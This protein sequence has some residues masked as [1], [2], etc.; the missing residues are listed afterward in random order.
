MKNF[1]KKQVPNC[2]RRTPLSELG[3][4][5][6]AIDINIYVYRFRGEEAW[7]VRFE[8]LF[9]MLKIHNI[10]PLCIFDS[11]SPV[12]KDTVRMQRGV[13]RLQTSKKIADLEYGLTRTSEETDSWSPARTVDETESLISRLKNKNARI[14][15]DMIVSLH[16]LMMERRIPFIYAPMEAETMC[17]DLCQTGVVDAVMSEDTDLY[18][19]ITPVVWS[20]FDLANECVLV[21]SGS[22]IPLSLGLTKEEFLDFCILCGT[23][24]NPAV[25]CLSFDIAFWLV[26]IFGSIEEIIAQLPEVEMGML[27][28][29]RVRELY[30]TVR[31]GTIA[32][33]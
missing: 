10:S 4:T 32:P 5:R 25:P 20:Q 26:Q 21:A 18:G 13:Q 11:R 19:Y 9:D 24:Y 28:H 14:S 1:M 2:F 15:T 7:I 6:V 3:L 29:V 27:N 16:A 33:V 31:D 12:E 30:R 8:K 17:H 22:S 23:D